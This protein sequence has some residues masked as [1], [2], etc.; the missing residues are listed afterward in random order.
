MWQREL[1]AEMPELP[2]INDYILNCDKQWHFYHHIYN[3]NIFIFKIFILNAKA[4]FVQGDTPLPNAKSF[5]SSEWGE[6]SCFK[7]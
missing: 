6:K 4:C 3:I 2:M 1:F 7:K 5:C